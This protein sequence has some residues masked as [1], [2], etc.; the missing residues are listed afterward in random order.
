M[1]DLQLFNFYYELNFFKTCTHQDNITQHKTIHITLRHPS[2][3]NAR[4]LEVSWQGSGL[5]GCRSPA[6]L[7]WYKFDWIMRLIN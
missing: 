5:L 1:Y 2:V 6:G 3:I 4:E 7:K